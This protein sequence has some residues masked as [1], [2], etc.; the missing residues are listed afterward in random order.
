MVVIFCYLKSENYKVQSQLNNSF[1]FEISTSLFSIPQ[2]KAAKLNTRRGH[3]LE[4]IRYAMSFL[5]ICN[6]ASYV[7]I[8][9]IQN[10]KINM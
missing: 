4:E 9:Q 10:K 8:K 1:Y 2:C 6:I 5:S 7:K 3:L